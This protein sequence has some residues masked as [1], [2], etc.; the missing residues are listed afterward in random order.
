MNFKLNSSYHPVST[1]LALKYLIFLLSAS[2]ESFELSIL[3]FIVV[4]FFIQMTISL[5]Q[6]PYAIFTFILR[7]KFHFR[8][9]DGNDSPVELYC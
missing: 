3:Y 1:L 6:Y 4:F 5:F 2:K 7:I 8:K 9:Y